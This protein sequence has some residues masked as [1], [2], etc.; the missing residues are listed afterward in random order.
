MKV[1]PIALGLTLGVLWGGAMC[2]ISIVN[3]VNPSYGRDFLFVM[4]SVYPG[5]AGAGP[6][7]GTLMAT[8]YGSVDGFLGGLLVGW[9]YNFFLKRVTGK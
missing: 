1:S 2:L 5:I 8:I 6:I 3:L 9:I 4:A 7:A